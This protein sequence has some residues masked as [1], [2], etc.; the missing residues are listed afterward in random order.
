MRNGI[1][2]SLIA[3][4]L[5]LAVA[6]PSVSQLNISAEAQLAPQ[7]PTVEIPE[8]VTPDRIVNTI[9]H[10][11]FRPNP[12][13]V[14]QPVLINMWMQFETF[15]RHMQYVDSFKLTITKPD[16]KTDTFIMSSYP[17][18]G[19]SWKEIVPEQV[20]TYT[21]KF[22]FLG[23]FFPA[24][25]YLEGKIITATS[26]GTVLSQSQYHKPSS[27]GPYK[28]TVQ[29]EPVPLYP[30]SPLPTDYWTRP[31][32]PHNREWWRISGNYPAIGVYG[33]EDPEWP[34]NT[35]KYALPQ[36]GYVPYVPAPTSSHIVWKRQYALGGIVGGSI[37]PQSMLHNPGLSGFG[38]GDSVDGAPQIIYAGRG[39]WSV[40][41]PFNGITANVWQ[42]FDIRTGEVF[43]ERTDPPIEQR[44]TF[45]TYVP[46]SGPVEGSQAY[47]VRPLLGYIGNGRL[48]KYNPMNG[49]V[50]GNYSIAPLTTGTFYKDPYALSIQDLGA[51]AG[52][53]RYRLIE[54]TTMG[55]L[56][57]LTTTTGT[58]VVRNITWAWNALPTTVDFEARIAVRAETTRIRSYNLDTGSLLADINTTIGYGT[59]AGPP[60][61][62]HGKFAR[63][64]NDGHWHCWDMRTGQYLWKSELSSWPWATFGTY[65]S[66]SYG[67][68]ILSN[69]Y[70]AVA[71]INWTNGK[72][73]WV[74]TY[75]TYPYESP[76]T[77]PNGTTVHA[78]HSCSII[79]DGIYYTMN[80]EH[81]PSQPLKR[82]WKMHA[83][84]ITTGEGIWKILS[85]QS[86]LGTGSR[87]FQGAIADGYLLYS[88]AYTG[89]MYTVGKGK[90]QTT[91]SV[92]ATNVQV[93]Q[94]FTITG[95]V[96]D[97]SP[98][99]PGTAAISDEY[100]DSWM[101]Y[102]HMQMPRPNDAKGVNVTLSAIDPNKNFIK[103]GTATSDTNG[104]YGFTWAP[105]VPGL[106]QIIA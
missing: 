7:Q 34:A 85:C 59:F 9:A 65:G 95:T 56:A 77:G 2:S 24:G 96:V 92:P 10:L 99:Q 38:G 5:L 101:E 42:C 35:N 88:D 83:I 106:Y 49:A 22:E 84:N 60:L 67:G 26:G 17:A 52:A 70:D 64:Y 80:S 1:K 58:R 97:M 79:A 36:Y 44:P 40:V 87:A 3:L 100:M 8:G 94:L 62:D 12:V 32:H 103:I 6:I 90:S 43:W 20:G 47:E 30:A 61:A 102:L 75:E 98:A 51:A 78:W 53:D 71:A 46:P 23:N 39:Y 16:G 37:G 50:V 11:S 18:D 104:V 69:Q 41:K 68:M 82:D 76:Y 72:I 93:G 86:G 45:I 48:I 89:Y 74:Y 105:E 81:S 21:L 27:D 55:T 31:V 33:G 73:V 25:R 15:D 54:W 19:T 13:G 4:I 14:G 28:L 57:N 66:T 63:R 29:E 91:V